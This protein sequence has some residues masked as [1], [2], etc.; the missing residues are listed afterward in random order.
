MMIVM[1]REAT[2]EQIQAVCEA[3]HEYGL[4]SLVLARRAASCRWHS[5]RDSA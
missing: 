4:E 3:I 5:Q 2:E 1:K